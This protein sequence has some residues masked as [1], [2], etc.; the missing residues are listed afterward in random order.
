M[1]NDEYPAAFCAPNGAYKEPSPACTD[2][3]LS[4]AADYASDDYLTFED[5]PQSAKQHLSITYCDG[6]DIEAVFEDGGI[7][8]GTTLLYREGTSS[9]T[10]L[11]NTSTEASNQG[12]FGEG[13][14]AVI[15]IVAMLCAGRKGEE[16]ESR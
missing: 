9:H 15:L 10:L 14:F 12:I 8:C 1:D 4:L 3:T 11:P 16:S 2:E 5:L 13:L 7:T 6:H